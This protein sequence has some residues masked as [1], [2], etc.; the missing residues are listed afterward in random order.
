MNIKT[1]LAYIAFALSLT[2]TASFGQVSL[3]Q[4]A[5]DFG[6]VANDLATVVS[7]GIF[8]T[9]PD[10]FTAY[11]NAATTGDLAVID[12][13][14]GATTGN[15]AYIS[16]AVGGGTPAVYNIASI[17]QAGNG[18]KAY[19][20]Q[21]GEG[22]VALIYQLTDGNL[23]YISQLAATT[24]MAG[25]DQQSTTASAGYITQAGANHAALIIQK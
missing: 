17:S 19:I 25:I 2:T 16:Q 23:G 3:S 10:L 15:D 9:T 21:S 18:N 4:L 8:A 6:D 24:S 12:Q 14:G 11:V 1:N 20:E 7:P 22:N 5:T 13:G